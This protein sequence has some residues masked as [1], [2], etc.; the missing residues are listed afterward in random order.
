MARPAGPLPTMMM[1][2]AA[3]CSVYDYGKEGRGRDFYRI[4]KKRHELFAACP[5]GMPGASLKVG[6]GP[7]PSR[8]IVVPRGSLFQQEKF[9]LWQS[10]HM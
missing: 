3:R 2:I 7:S 10:T 8:T 9:Q 1:R 5:V 6:P 4:W